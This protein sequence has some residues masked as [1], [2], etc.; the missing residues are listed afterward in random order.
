MRIVRLATLAW[1]A[2]AASGGVAAAQGTTGSISGFVTDATHAAV[3]GATVTVRHV[4]TDQ[5][6]VVVTDAGGRYRA[7]A[8]SPGKYELTVELQGFRTTQHS[9]LSLSVGQ[10][11][12]VNVQL[13]LGALSERVV[14]T[15]EAA[16]VS[17][18]QSSVAALVD[19]KQIRELPLNGRDFSQ[20][21]LLQPGVTSS[22][23]TQRQVDRGMGTQ[24]SIAGARPNQISYQLDGTD[25]NTQGNGSPGSAAGGLLG[26]E[27]VREFQV[28]VNNYSAEYG[29]S[30]GGIVTAVT[31]SGTNA[32]KGTLFEFNRNNRFDSKTFFDAPDSEIPPLSRNQFGGYLGGPIVKD[33]T[34]FFGSYE[35]LRQNRGL[36]TI[37]MVPSRATRARTDINPITK[38]YLL[39]YPEPN[40]KETGATGLY[41]VQVTEPTRENYALGKVDQTISSTQSVSVR[42]SW[43]RAQ[44]DQDAAIPLWT[45]DTRTKSQS[46]VG[47]HK[48][49]IAS[50]LLNVAKAAWN[51]AYEATDNIEKI[52]FDPKLF[53]VPN[54]RFGNISVSGI[55]S[56]GPDTNTPTFVDLKSLQFIDNFT[57][58]HASH[59]VKT[60]VSITHYMND[61]DS[62]F[63]FGGNYAFTS[64]ENFAQNRPGT[65]EGQGPGSTTARRWRQN[66]IG[67][68]AQDDW[69]AGRNLTLNL[70]LRYEFFTTPTELDGRMA[71][72]PDLQGASTS[73]GG[74]IFQN[75][76][77]KNV[78]PRV[79]FAWN[80]TGDG[81]NALHGG[82]GYFFEPILSNIYRA[83]GNRTPPYYSLINP[84]NPTF[85]TPPTS[86]TSSL[87][88][89]D[90]V[91]YNIKN[92]YR[93]QYN[94]TYQRELPGKTIVTGGFVGSRGY[95]Q[96][97]NVEYNQSI[98]QIQANGTFFF[99]SATRRN[100]NFGSMR[101]RTSDG[102]SWYKGLILGASRRFSG[103]LAM[104]ASYT[105][106][107]SE[108]LGSQA[109]GSADFDNSFQPRYAFDP[110]DNK[111]LSDFDIR[112]NFVFNSTWELP[113]GKALTG[114]ARAIADGWQLSS[115]VTIRS[116]IPFTPVL[117]FDRARAAP[118][119]G[120]AGQTP[121]LVAG[122]SSNPVLGGADQY[123]DP[124]CFS[125]PALGTFGNVPRNTIIGPGFGTWD[126]AV[127]KNLP[128]TGGRKI[129]LRAEAFNITNHVNFGLPATTV[130]NSAGRVSSAGQI[131]S[132]VGT[133]RQFQFGV[134]VEF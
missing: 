92:P 77:L 97:R 118:R 115:I 10:D 128:M 27:T 17:T 34:F 127:F 125:L 53:F 52:A 117:A 35:G 129:Q 131:T 20:L 37:A 105:L 79:G 23:S 2:L 43:D 40:G 38:P 71:S 9:D 61:Q 84:A 130:F 113:F 94:L 111:G 30:T 116:G 110:M 31:R 8:L 49:V 85:P 87:L 134:K 122:C 74:P 26:V 65:Y 63:D 57:W 81:K 104:Q 15:G 114:A 55:N 25:A 21:T 67:L 11:A 54:T 119:S 3:P 103:G 45:T 66:L 19:E 69:S 126:M 32:Y 78:A 88:R 132:I 60:G 76:S 28:L 22:P 64:L 121:D 39:L 51:R 72:M 89:L 13:E 80:V 83:Y 73:R 102:L 29:R 101:L 6:R 96:I 5:K 124:N 41:S 123:F 7:Q 36:T 86:G 108:D 133:A 100:P 44:V 91:D 16:L 68:Y 82:A 12:V 107:K 24:V 62:S 4:E 42:Y 58:S 93:L 106:G 98:P 1:F 99:P 120:G 14:V 47:E 109:V 18:H 90:L 95:K 48:W 33:R 112:H 75:P 70:G 56:I 59:N 46:I 50:N